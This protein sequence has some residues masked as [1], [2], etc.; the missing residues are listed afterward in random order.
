MHVIGGVFSGSLSFL[1]PS[2]TNPVITYTGVAANGTQTQ[3]L[4]WPTNSSDPYLIEWAKEPTNPVIRVGASNAGPEGRDD[5]TAW[6]V[7]DQWYMVYGSG[8]SKTYG[9]AELYV[10]PTQGSGAFREWTY[11]HELYRNSFGGFWEVLTFLGLLVALFF[12]SAACNYLL[13]SALQCPDFFPL[14]AAPEAY[15][16]VLKASAGGQDW[17]TTGQYDTA[18]QK[19]LPASAVRD[20]GAAPSQL[21]DHGQ[22]YASKSFLAP[23]PSS[24]VGSDA[25]NR[26]IVFG[27]VTE[28]D[29]SGVARG[30]SGVQS[31]PRVM[32]PSPLGDGALLFVPVQELQSLRGQHY[33]AV[34]ANV[35]NS[36][37]LRLPGMQS[38]PSSLSR[39]LSCLVRS[40]YVGRSGK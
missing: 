24:A 9:A 36:G 19:F 3:C 31:L 27:W 4:A 7:N 8:D 33:S 26:Q 23:P 17:Y 5:T 18:Q 38:P 29:V 6:Q 40:K 34:N 1:G 25:T 16:Y 13:I 32:L 20:I 35:T 28:N 12:S 2:N 22:F 39:S 30:W 14:P 21:L 11:V 37:P 10:A 15:R